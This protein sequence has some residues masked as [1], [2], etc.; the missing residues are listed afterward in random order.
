VFIELPLR[1]ATGDLAQIAAGA[2]QAASEALSSAPLQ[3]WIEA[4]QLPAKQESIL[5]RWAKEAQNP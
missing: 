4:Q 1:D 3:A 5:D 2:L